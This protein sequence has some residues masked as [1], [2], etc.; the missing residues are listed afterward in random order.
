MLGKHLCHVR[1]SLNPRRVENQGGKGHTGYMYTLAKPSLA[2]RRETLEQLK[3]VS[4][5]IFRN[6]GGVSSLRRELRCYAGD[7]LCSRVHWSFSA[8]PLVVVAVLA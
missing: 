5:Q 3:I 4:L 2:E 1:F 6:V 7:R 8:G